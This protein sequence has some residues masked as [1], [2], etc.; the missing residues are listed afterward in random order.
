MVVGTNDDPINRPNVTHITTN[1]TDVRAEIPTSDDLIGSFMIIFLLPILLFDF[2]LCG[3]F[4]PFIYICLKYDAQTEMQH[5]KYCNLPDR[6]W[7][8]QCFE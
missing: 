7:T 6:L 2:A 4:F 1:S 5:K 3:R 8:V